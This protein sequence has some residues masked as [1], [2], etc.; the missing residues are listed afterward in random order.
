M[1]AAPA[2]RDGGHPA[3]EE[4]L[5][6][7]TTL[8]LCHKGSGLCLHTCT[9]HHKHKPDRESMSI[10]GNHGCI[11]SFCRFARPSARAHSRTDLSYDR[12]GTVQMLGWRTSA[13]RD[14]VHMHAQYS[15]EGEI[16]IYP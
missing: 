9:T 12:H 11:I 10:C 16:D 14:E 1:P 13:S 6:M 4:I 7:E 3:F 8:L 5:G 15:G 2:L